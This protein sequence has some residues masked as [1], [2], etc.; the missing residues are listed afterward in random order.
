M[1]FQAQHRQA[2]EDCLAAI[3][4]DGSAT[5]QAVEDIEQHLAGLVGTSS[6]KGAVLS[7]AAIWNA[8]AEVAFTL[9]KLTEAIKHLAVAPAVQA[10]PWP[11][12]VVARYLNLAGAYVDVVATFVYNEDPVEVLCRGCGRDRRVSVSFNFPSDL[13][14]ARVK[15]VEGAQR[16][17]QEH[18]ESCRAMTKPEVP[19]LAAA[20]GRRS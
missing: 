16:E 8:L 9:P 12:G 15:A 13:D 11:E 19:S 17:A 18:A 6:S 7:L 20:N 14:D 2:I 5:R 1:I 10:E 4:D 3:R